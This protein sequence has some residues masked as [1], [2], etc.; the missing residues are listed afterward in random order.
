MS[1]K[2]EVE[3]DGVVIGWRL[4]VLVAVIILGLYVSKIIAPI[5]DRLDALEKR[6]EKLLHDL[7]ILGDSVDRIDREDSRVHKQVENLAEKYN[8][9]TN[10]A[11]QHKEEH[12]SIWRVLNSHNQPPG[13]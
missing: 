6:Q 3:R 9:L 4:V 11:A 1:E 13:I 7:D 8:A 12:I 5:T 10:S 2:L